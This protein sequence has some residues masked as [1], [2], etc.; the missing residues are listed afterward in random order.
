[1]WTTSR[2]I[3]DKHG[4]RAGDRVLQNLT[5]LWKTACAR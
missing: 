2:A 5:D 4:H 1:M 3:N